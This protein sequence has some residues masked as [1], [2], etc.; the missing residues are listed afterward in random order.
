MGGIA[1]GKRNVVETEGWGQDMV[2]DM[3]HFD[4]EQSGLL[5]VA[6]FVGMMAVNIELK[7]GGVLWGG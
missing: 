3:I 6:E 2:I 5:K 7:P 1:E 4:Q